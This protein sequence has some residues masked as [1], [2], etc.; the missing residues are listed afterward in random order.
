M[1]LVELVELVEPMKLVEADETCRT[2]GTWSGTDE[3]LS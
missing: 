1:D 2:D 3:T